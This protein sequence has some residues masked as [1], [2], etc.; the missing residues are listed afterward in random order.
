[1]AGLREF[2]NVVDLD[3]TG[4]CLKNAVREIEKLAYLK[5]LNLSFNSISHSWVCS[6]S[7][8]SLNL[9]NNQLRDLTSFNI[10]CL[11]SLI[12]IDVSHNFLQDISGI[13]HLSRLKHFIA[14]DNNISNITPLEQLPYLEECNL[15]S[16]DL[17][18]TQIIKS[19]SHLKSLKLLFLKDT[20][21]FKTIAQGATDG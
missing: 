8:E 1:M 7:L 20:P 10:T 11:P 21:I 18:D 2:K 15:S 4:N 13:Q 6:K 16:N 5:K 17:A 19:I 9:N 3:L 14:H 12:H